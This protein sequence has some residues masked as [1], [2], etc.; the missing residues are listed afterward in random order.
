MAATSATYKKAVLN[1]L[2]GGTKF[3]D[4]DLRVMLMTTSYAPDLLGHDFQSHLSGE[5]VAAG[6]TAGGAALGG[7]ALS[8]N[9]TTD[10]TKLT[11]NPTL[12]SGIASAFRYAVVYNNTPVAASAKPL[13][14][15]VD[16]Q[17]NIN[18]GGQDFRINWNELGLLDIS[19]V[20]P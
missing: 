5:L 7:R 15:L 3:E 9:A 16:F 2:R 4:D 1:A 19:P 13:L 14:V 10:K 18:P 17:E 20:A 11:A 8:Y 12:W 6:Y